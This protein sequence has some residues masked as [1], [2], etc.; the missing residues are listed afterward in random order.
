MTDVRCPMCG[1]TNPADVEVCGYCEARLQPLAGNQD[2]FTWQEDSRLEQEE[3]IPDWLKELRPPGEEDIE[4]SEDIFSEAVGDERL[5]EVLRDDIQEQGTNEDPADLEPSPEANDT[6]LESDAQIWS[7]K[8]DDYSIIDQQAAER[9]GIVK[10]L[11]D[12]F[13]NFEVEQEPE[14]LSRPEAEETEV[15][16]PDE[17]QFT[18]EDVVEQE[19]PDWFSKLEEK[20]VSDLPSQLEADE[21]EVEITSE[22]EQPLPEEKGE[23]QIE[24]SSVSEDPDWLIKIRK[25]HEEEEAERNIREQNSLDWLSD[26]PYSN[27]QKPVEPDKLGEVSTS[28]EED[29]GLLSDDGER[30]YGMVDDDSI[31]G[32]LMR[33]EKASQ[34]QAGPEEENVLKEDVEGEELPDW[35]ARFSEEHSEEG[36]TAELEERA[37]I[38]PGDLPDWLEAMRPID[39]AAPSIP[40]IGEEDVR[41]EKVGPLAGLKAVIPAEPEFAHFKK[42]P[43]YSIKLNVT[44]HQQAHAD[45]LENMLASEEEAKPI[46]ARPRITSQVLLR[47]LLTVILLLAILI[48]RWFDMGG[49]ILPAGVIEESAVVHQQVD[50]LPAGAPVLIGFDFEPGLAAELDLTA[51]L[52]I[53]E[54]W[55]RNA[56]LV[57]V[58]TIAVGPINAERYIKALAEESGQN[59]SYNNLGFI[60]GGP[61]GLRSFAENPSRTL[62]FNLEAVSPWTRAPFDEIETA[63]D[64]AMLVVITENPETARAWI[65]QVHMGIADPE[66]PFIMVVSAQAEPLVRPYYMP[67][68]A[69]QVTGLIVGWAGGAAMESLVG[70]PGPISENWTIFGMGLTAAAVLLLAGGLVSLILVTLDKRNKSTHDEDVL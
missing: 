44:D 38:S 55:Q 21:S 5:S 39:T 20:Q 69:G 1:K 32:W 3:D 42:R 17:E 34:E 57:F 68:M 36:E 67:G 15:E 7:E 50:Q 16:A 28:A 4:E 46:P 37:E 66:L 23:E 14:M 65:E 25:R 18:S 47:L 43:A 6:E 45:L 60:A 27:V 56:N 26:P 33:L 40:L 64:F 59:A 8:E 48:P 63:A 24:E 22:E 31:P 58:S 61:A 9:E 11:P 41:P 2:E 29:Y 53:S 10:D 19:L 13:S 35:L 30:E 62:P 12:W 70:R 54:L 49:I 52:L 51:E